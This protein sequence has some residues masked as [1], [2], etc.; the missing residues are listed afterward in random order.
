MNI[1]QYTLKGFFCTFLDGKI[2]WNI[3]KKNLKTNPLL[4][5]TD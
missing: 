3:Y 4:K 1:M 5:G 2:I